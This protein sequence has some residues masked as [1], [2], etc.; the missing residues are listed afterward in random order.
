MMKRTVLILLMTA[1]LLGQ[2]LLNAGCVIRP[3]SESVSST[4]NNRIDGTLSDSVISLLGSGFN[5]E[6]VFS[7]AGL[8][9]DSI[10]AGH[11]RFSVNG[12]KQVICDL[13]IIVTRGT[14]VIK[15]AIVS[16]AA[17]HKLIFSPVPD[18]K[19][20]N[21]Y[22]IARNGKTIRLGSFWREDDLFDILG[23][24]DATYRE[25]DE[26]S[27]IT[28]LTCVYDGLT[29]ELSQPKDPGDSGAWLLVAMTC[30]ENGYTSPRGLQP[31]LSY[32]EAINLLG[33]GDF[34]VCPDRLPF[35]TRLTICKTT[36]NN[37][38]RIEL[39]VENQIVTTITMSL[40]ET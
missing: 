31:G 15:T 8:P 17:G 22:Q 36:V 24:P 18:S 34:I 38:S 32:R 27:G 16:D 26:I 14:P 7:L 39:T 40:S 3:S 13:Q 21:D 19:N 20:I 1:I 11:Y 10:V 23:E 2:S 25:T 35:P 9:A 5:A 4:Q 37:G 33:T 28:M 6:P 29:L 30:S 12:D